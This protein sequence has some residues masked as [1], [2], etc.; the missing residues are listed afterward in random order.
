[1]RTDKAKNCV[2]L[3]SGH[4]FRAWEGK[5]EEGR[6]EKQHLTGL[7]SPLLFFVTFHSPVGN[8]SKLNSG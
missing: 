7:F 5:R 1:M 6:I 3:I 2:S 4:L 8:R